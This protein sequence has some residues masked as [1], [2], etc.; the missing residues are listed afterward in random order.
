MDG[1]GTWDTDT[2]KTVIFYMTMTSEGHLKSV[3]LKKGLFCTERRI[4]KGGKTSQIW[5]PLEHQPTNE[6]LIQIR[7]YY[8]KQKG[9]H[10]SKK[11]V[12]AF[13]RLSPSLEA[14]L[15]M[16]FEYW[17]N[18]AENIRTLPYHM[19]NPKVVKKNMLGPIQ[20]S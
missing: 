20:T 19:G 7:R 15:D 17:L 4:K 10:H 2:G 14:K 6:T 3:S 18:I 13:E 1:C 9:N 8:T 5:E 11:R 12:T 16:A